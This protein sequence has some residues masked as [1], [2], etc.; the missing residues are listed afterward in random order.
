MSWDSYASSKGDFS[1]GMKIAYIK[2]KEGCCYNIDIA[3]KLHNIN[4]INE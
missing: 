2:N 3:L 1:H 4:H